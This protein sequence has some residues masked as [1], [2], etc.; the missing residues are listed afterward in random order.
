[1]QAQAYEHPFKSGARRLVRNAFAF[2]LGG[3]IILNIFFVASDRHTHASATLFLYC[4][5]IGA[6]VGFAAWLLYRLARFA[7]RT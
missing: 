6:P 2:W 5:L 4:L 3:A 1:M 7:A